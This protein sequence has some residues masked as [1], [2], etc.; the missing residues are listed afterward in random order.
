ME[1]IASVLPYSSI[2]SGY[3]CLEWNSNNKKRKQLLK[4]DPIYH[5]AT[6]VRFYKS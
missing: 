1:Q 6:D 4:S 2:R 5:T 3:D